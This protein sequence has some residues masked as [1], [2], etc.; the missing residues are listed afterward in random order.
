MLIRLEGSK[1]YIRLEKDNQCYPLGLHSGSGD[2][3]TYLK[4][5]SLFVTVQVPG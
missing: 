2:F 5:T 1:W 3:G 4:A